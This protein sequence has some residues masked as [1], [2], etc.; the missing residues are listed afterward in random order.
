M[1]KRDL[2]TGSVKK[3]LLYMSLPTM[4]GFFAQTLYDVVDMMWIGRLSVDAL[5]GVTIFATIIWLV[6]V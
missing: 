5:A 4:A 6:E 3:N 1:K 2:T